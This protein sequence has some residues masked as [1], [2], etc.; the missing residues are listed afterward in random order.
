[1]T[2]AERLPNKSSDFMRQPCDMDDPARD[3]TRQDRVDFN[4]ISGISARFPKL[5]KTANQKAR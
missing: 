4:S 2:T 5:S 3:D 1:V